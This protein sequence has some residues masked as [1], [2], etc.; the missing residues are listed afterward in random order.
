MT[1]GYGR[2]GMGIS[3]DVLLEKRI[4]TWLQLVPKIIAHLQIKSF[5]LMSHSAGTIYALNT[6]WHCRDLLGE[7]PYLALLGTYIVLSQWL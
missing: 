1:C 3:T 7:R 2:F 4:S 5:A 6:L